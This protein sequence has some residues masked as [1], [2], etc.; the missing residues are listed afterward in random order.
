MER[1]H[2]PAAPS[3]TEETGRCDETLAQAGAALRI[4][5]FENAKRRPGYWLDHALRWWTSSRF[6]Q[7][8]ARLIARQQRSIRKRRESLRNLLGQS[9]AAAPQPEPVCP[10]FNERYYKT[11]W[12]TKRRPKASWWDDYRQTGW[13]HGYNPH[14]LFDVEW[15]LA[16]NP[17]VQ[18]AGEEPLAHFLNKG[19][20]KGRDPSPYFQTD[21]Y[22]ANNPEVLAQNINPLLH[23][24]EVGWKNG[25]DPGPKFSLRR[26][27][28]A[29]PH[30]DKTVEPLGEWMQELA[31]GQ[32]ADRRREYVHWPV[33]YLPAEVEPQPAPHFGKIA[34]QLH[35]FYL[36]K[37]D[38]ILEHLRHLPVRFDLLV[39]T[40][41]PEHALEITAIVEQSGLDCGLDIRCTP[42]RGR[43]VAPLVCLFGRKLLDYDCALHIHTKKSASVKA[44]ADYGHQW[45]LHNLGFLARNREYV[46]A[47]LS[48]FASTP[49][50][51]ILAPQ[52]WKG[53][54][55][56]MTWTSNRPAAKALMERL[57][58]SPR[59]LKTQPLMF[60]SG[61]MFWFRPA[62]LQPLLASDLQIDDFPPEPLPNDGT[63]AHAIERCILYIALAQGYHSLVIAPSLYQPTS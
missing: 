51:G 57:H 63:L 3:H 12:P 54:R 60:P 33:T 31:V 42:N 29:S 23:Y 43:D 13:K 18:A 1:P 30:A 32:E 21:W 7:P 39:S 10:L 25:R 58:L 37:L 22:I 26:Y 55:H 6:T 36:D 24:L 15:Y 44:D 35:A 45:L 5:H 53:V 9:P 34:V 2:L 59:A 49:N 27:F 28:E 38:L 17:D 14:P 50:C 11:Q 61:T 56:V 46:T 16:T 19:W 48:L 8:L 52:P 4:R 20:E 40:D 47:I 62:A 41:T